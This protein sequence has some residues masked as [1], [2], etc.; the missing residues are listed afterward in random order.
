MKK[1]LVLKILEK[2]DKE[3]KVSSKEDLSLDLQQYG[4]IIEIMSDGGLIIGANVSRSG[5]GNKVHMCWT[6]NIKITI[7]GIEYLEHNS[8]HSGGKDPDPK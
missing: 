3:S 6:D 4:E 5:Q 2:L 1:E 8:K 7:Q